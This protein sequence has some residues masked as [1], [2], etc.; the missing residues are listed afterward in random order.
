MTGNVSIHGIIV[1]AVKR[2]PFEITLRF[3]HTFYVVAAL[4]VFL[5][6]IAVRTMPADIFPET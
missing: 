4:L 5:G 6:V 2:Y 3:P 1:S